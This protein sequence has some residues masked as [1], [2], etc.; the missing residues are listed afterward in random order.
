MIHLLPNRSK[1]TTEIHAAGAGKPC[2]HT[3]HMGTC[4]YCQR[5]Q[6]AR[7]RAQLDGAHS[8]ATR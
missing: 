3:R 7:W 6:L 4:P 1:G 2:G 5:A 8:G